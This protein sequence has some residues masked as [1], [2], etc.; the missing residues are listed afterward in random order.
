MRATVETRFRL[1]GK[2]LKDGRMLDPPLA[3]PLCGLI[4][5]LRRRP[6]AGAKPLALSDVSLIDEA[7]GRS[8]G[9]VAELAREVEEAKAA[10]GG[11]GSGVKAA[12][13]SMSELEEYAENLCLSWTLP[14]Y[15]W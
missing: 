6:T 12:V 3:L 14:G 7:L 9:S 15:P 4:V 13:R 2:A 1:M 5:G 10:L 11:E 8:L